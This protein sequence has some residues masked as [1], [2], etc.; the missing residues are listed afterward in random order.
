MDL[1]G[2]CALGRV[3]TP[4]GWLHFGYNFGYDVSNADKQRPSLGGA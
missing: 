2:A 1:D 4:L 3:A